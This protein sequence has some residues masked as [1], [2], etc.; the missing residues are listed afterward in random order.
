[1]TLGLISIAATVI[2]MLLINELI[3]SSKQQNGRKILLLTSSGTV[4]TVV[5]T[6]SLI[7]RVFAA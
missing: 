4:L 2:W 1:M 6:I 7:Q 5:L 3:K